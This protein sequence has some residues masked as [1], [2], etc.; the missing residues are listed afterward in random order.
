MNDSSDR[1]AAGP[2]PEKRGRIP[3]IDGLRGAAVAAMV[4]YHGLWD[5]Q[6]LGIA[7]LDLFT[8]PHW[9]AFRAV[10][11]VA[12]L[13]LVGVS[14]TLAQGDRPRP[15]AFLR[16]L[17]VVAAAA[18]AITAATW[19][20]VPDGLVTFGVLHHI[21]VASVLALPFLRLPVWAVVAGAAFA[22]SA[23]LLYES[24]HFNGRALAWTGLASEPPFAV[25]HVP[26]LPWFGV[27]LLGM[28]AGRRVVRARRRL[29]AWS[30]GGPAWRAIL[31]TGRHS[32]AVYL[33]HQ[34][35]LMGT[36]WL[37]AGMPD[38]SPSADPGSAFVERCRAGC[39][40][41]GQSA[42]FCTR[43]CG[44]ILDGL[45]AEGALDAVIAGRT[46]GDAALADLPAVCAQS[47]P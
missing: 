9:L 11:L 14:L 22:L 37:A 42:A 2:P 26:L 34:P 31:W 10:I 3:A 12:F 17:A 7:Q 40:D 38:V 25:D 45:M 41:N 46:S 19:R 18:L 36:I 35:L 5:I 16:R 8:A 23:P 44:C 27:V 32:L 13:A 29:A 4:V 43:Y 21:V 33:L 20:F 1:P 28:V 24:A 15:A 30:P 47:P 39:G 6:Y